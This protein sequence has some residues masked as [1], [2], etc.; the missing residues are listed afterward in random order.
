MSA[1]ESPL[2]QGLLGQAVIHVWT[3]DKEIEQLVK[4][5]GKNAAGGPKGGRQANGKGADQPGDNFPRACQAWDGAEKQPQKGGKGKR[6]RSAAPPARNRACEGC[7]S[8]TCPGAEPGPGVGPLPNPGQ[9]AEQTR[10]NGDPS[11]SGDE[12]DDSE[13][14][15]PSRASLLKLIK[16]LVNAKRQGASFRSAFGMMADNALEVYRTK[17][18]DECQKMAR[19][20]R[21]EG[22]E[23]ALKV[24]KEYADELKQEL[25]AAMA[26]VPIPY[27]SDAM[28]Q[29]R[30]EA[31]DT[32]DKTW[33]ALEDWVQREVQTDSRLGEHVR[34]AWGERDELG[35]TKPAAAQQSER[36]RGTD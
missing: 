13:V 26:V 6:G 19:F 3:T 29:F 27:V 12:S 5:K 2:L 35:R 22:R 20:L 32:A 36:S 4:G 15:D 8:A 21:A 28:R 17:I 16:V 1:Y 14:I 33:V 10:R 23:M 9:D 7:G 25:E 24:L 11:V 18:A 31:T 34:E 30:S